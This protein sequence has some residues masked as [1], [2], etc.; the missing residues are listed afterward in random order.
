MMIEGTLNQSKF[1]DK[2]NQLKESENSKTEP[3]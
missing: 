3:K 1:Q 2:D